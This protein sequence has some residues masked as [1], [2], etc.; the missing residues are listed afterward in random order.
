MTSTL[1]RKRQRETGDT[2]RRRQCEGRDCSKA[3]SGNDNSHQKLEEAKQRVSPGA[4]GEVQPCQHLACRPLA[5]ELW[6][7]KFLLPSATQ[8][9]GK[10]LHQPQEINRTLFKVSALPQQDRVTTHGHTSQ[11]WAPPQSVHQF[12]FLLL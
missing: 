12:P 7:S 6:G 11:F 10:L 5:T 4:S 1:T 3:A 9:F 2:K 8:L